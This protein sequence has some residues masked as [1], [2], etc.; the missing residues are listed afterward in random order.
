MVV[1]VAVAAAAKVP[2]SSARVLF[3]PA[4]VMYPA[5]VMRNGAPKMSVVPTATVTT[6]APEETT[7]L[8]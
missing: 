1:A 5:S 6:L 4:R 2:A 8:I 7:L 3:Q